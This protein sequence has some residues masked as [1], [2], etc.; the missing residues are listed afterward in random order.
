MVAFRVVVSS[1]HPKILR[2][3]TECE[4][5]G[6]VKCVRCAVGGPHEAA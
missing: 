4:L 1:F 6:V 2:I 3:V 5:A